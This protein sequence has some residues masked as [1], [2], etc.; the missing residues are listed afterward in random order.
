LSGCLQRGA[1]QQLQEQLPQ[2]GR[3]DTVAWQH[4]GQE[5]RKGLSAAA[6][7]ASARTINP[8]APELLAGGI[9]GVVAVEEAV[10][11]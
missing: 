1:C 6:A 9:G 5:N 10:A 2:P 3:G 4:V 7:L 11:V 8:L